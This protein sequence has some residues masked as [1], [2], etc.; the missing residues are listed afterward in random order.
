M[1]RAGAALV[2]RQ[3]D[4]PQE[5]RKLASLFDSRRTPACRNACLRA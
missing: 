5:A 4:V 1:G 2:A 3:Q